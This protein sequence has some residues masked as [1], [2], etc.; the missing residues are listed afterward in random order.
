MNLW[1][2][3]TF[4]IDSCFVFV[5]PSAQNVD[6]PFVFKCQDSLFCL[7]C[8]S[9][10][11]RAHIK[12]SMSQVTCT[13]DFD[14]R[15]DVALPYTSNTD[16]LNQHQ[17]KR[18][19]ATKLKRWSSIRKFVLRRTHDVLTIDSVNGPIWNRQLKFLSGK[20]FLT[21]FQQNCPTL[22]LRIQISITLRQ[23][24]KEPDNTAKEFSAM[25]LQWIA[26]CYRSKL[27]RHQAARTS[28]CW[29]TSNNTHLVFQTNKRKNPE[30]S[31]FQLLHSFGY[32]I[33]LYSST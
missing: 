30:A 17:S 9:Q 29:R 3:L 33:A 16:A 25:R 31:V 8:E 5:T 28:T 2:Y 15:T 1:T 10:T 23:H 20:T 13:V 32:F 19:V 11:P 6:K 27:T 21:E 7:W 22:Y 14:W 26:R 24:N 4:N 18:K 12:E